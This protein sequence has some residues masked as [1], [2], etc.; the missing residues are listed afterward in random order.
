MGAKQSLTDDLIQFKLTAKEIARDARKAQSKADSESKKVALEMKRGNMA[1]AQIYAT[2]AIREKSNYLQLLKLSSQLDGV[3]SRLEYAIRMQKTSATMANTVKG[4]SSVM[5]SMDVV[6]IAANMEQ[7]SKVFEDMDVAS[8]V[9]G[10]TMDSA[11]SLSTPQ[12]EVRGGGT[13]RHRVGAGRRGVGGGLMP[14][15]CFDFSFR[16]L[17][18]SAP[19]PRLIG[20]AAHEADRRRG[21]AGHSKPAGRRR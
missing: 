10:K 18:L 7:F 13:L 21:R 14:P 20:N 8:D 9:M 6:K 12:D 2:N 19:T 16:L 11:N 4:M 17:T 5:K 1:G 15:I 3:A